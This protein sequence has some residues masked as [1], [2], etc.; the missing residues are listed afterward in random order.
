[1]EK[2]IILMGVS[3]CGKSSVGKA[4]EAKLGWKFYDGDDFHPQANIDKMASGIPLNDDDRMPWLKNL[5][6]LVFEQNQLGKSVIVACSALKKSYRD[7]LRDQNPGL[8]FVHL[9]GDFDLILKRMQVRENHYM[10]A[11]MLKSQFDTLEIPQNA[12]RIRIDRSVEDIVKEIIDSL[13][14]VHKELEW[15]RKQILD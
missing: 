12:I 5:H 2:T 13:N 7:I 1:M 14:V 3:G 8:I 10:R 11:E 15:Q 6:D 9:D 4:L